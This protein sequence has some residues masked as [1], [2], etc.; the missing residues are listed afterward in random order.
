MVLNRVTLKPA[1]PKR[2]FAAIAALMT[3][4]ETEPT[5][6]SSLRDWYNRQQENGIRFTVAMY[7][8]GKL[9]GFNALYRENLNR[10]PVY[11]KT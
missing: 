4:V 6:E 11:G 1:D 5:T 9:L 8:A 2:H 10:D 3:S 7:P